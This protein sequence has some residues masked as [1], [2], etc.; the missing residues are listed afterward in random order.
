MGGFEL[1]MCLDEESPRKIEELATEL[2]V[3]ESAIRERFEYLEQFDF[4]ERVSGG[5]LDTGEHDRFKRS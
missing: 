2:D 1:W 3:D 4:A 5:I